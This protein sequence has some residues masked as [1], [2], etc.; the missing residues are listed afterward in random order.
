LQWIPD[1]SIDEYSEATI[2]FTTGNIKSTFTLKIV[3][4]TDK[5]EWFEKE[6]EIA[7]K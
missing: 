4:Y 7:V 2:R 1:L 6:A 5:G 3:G